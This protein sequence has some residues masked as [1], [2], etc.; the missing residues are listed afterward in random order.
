M[1]QTFYPIVGLDKSPEIC[2]ARHFTGDHIT[3]AMSI[4]EPVPGIRFEVFDRKR[5][6]AIFYIDRG[7][8]GFDFLILLERLARMLDPFGPR[9][10]G[11]V[12]ETVNSLFDLDKCAEISQIPHTSFDSRPDTIALLQC[13]PGI[14]FDLFD[15][16]A[17]PAG[18]LIDLEHLR[19]DILPRREEFRRMFHPLRPAHLRDMHQTFDP[20][21]E[22]DK[23]AVIGQRDYLP[24]N[25][26]PDRI[27]L[28]R[29]RPRVRDQLFVSEADALFVLIELEHFHLNRLAD[30][31]QFVWILDAT[32]RHI[33]DVQ[34]T[35]ESAEINE[36]AIFRNI[37]DLT[38]DDDSLFEVFE[39]FVLPPIDLFFE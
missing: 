8:D 34:Q 7:N 30:S 2:E 18:V 27:T 9:N 37:L 29:C 13:L 32:P 17:D 21:F 35:I 1:A 19:F 16:E 15:A 11:D 38:F 4:E 12:N 39:G 3:K 31:E 14:R 6:P 23:S 25:S 26:R 20:R 33:G 24:S 28:D 36:G 10:V 22:F 5:K